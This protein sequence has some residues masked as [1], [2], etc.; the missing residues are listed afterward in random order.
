ML[1][2][3]VDPQLPPALSKYLEKEGFDAKHTTDTIQSHL[4][5]DQEI[6]ELA[7]L[8]KRIIV[9]KDQAFMDH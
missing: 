1:S 9:T 2:F 4:L 5:K 3:I 6:I 8:E 7:M